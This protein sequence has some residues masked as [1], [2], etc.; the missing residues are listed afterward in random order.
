[1]S[2]TDETLKI[3]EGE[4]RI[5]AS[6]LRPGVHVRLPG[7]WLEHQFMFSSFVIADM[8]QVKQ[9]TAMNLPQL[10][11]DLARC[12][13]PPLPKQQASATPD[14]ADE[15]EKARLAA[16]ATKQLAEKIERAKAMDK[17]RDRMDKAQKHYASASKMVSSV[18]KSFNADLKENVRKI[19]TV[20]EESTAALM[21]ETDSAI[22]L[23]AEKGYS[24]GSTAHALSVMTLSLLLGKQAQLPAQALHTLGI[25]ALLH[26]IGKSAIST[27]ILRSTERNKHEE[28]VY[29]THCR[30]GYENALR[31]GNLSQPVLDAILHHH[32]RIDGG[33]F[34]DQ[35]AGEKIPLAA[36]IV[37]IANR[38]DNLA[39]PINY[40]R[41]ISPA[42][43]LSMMWAKEQK[44]FD[45]V[46]LQLFVRAMGVYP[47]GSIVQLTDGRIG[48]VV[49]SAT[50][51][52]LLSP[53]VM[54]YEPGV[55]QR[56]AIIIDLT[57]ESSVKIDRA[58]RLQDR[59]DDELDYLLPRRK[60]SWAH[61][62]NQQSAA[63]KSD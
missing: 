17:L 37:A 2:A 11:C 6:Q 42:E 22:M 24:E 47:P 10:F 13:V 18:L 12:K 31:A 14:Q 15:K 38:F 57:Q 19:S 35:L 30:I 39:N 23:I 50:I 40:Q 7:P 59:T 5:D 26:D 33:G 41:A 3:Q 55:P 60:M 56:Q 20:S 8:D 28:A 21:T 48:A 46:L 45:N 1:M 54:I 29:M 49:I 53:Q 25:G 36:R 4:I 62:G 58:L 34:P 16:L 51:Q 27:S 52:D 61:I 9:I 63:D 32:E 43:A 44:A